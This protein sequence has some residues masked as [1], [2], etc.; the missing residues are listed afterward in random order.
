ME[1]YENRKVLKKRLILLGGFT[2]LFFLLLGFRLYLIQIY[3]NPVYSEQALKQRGREI[4]LN[5]KR[6]IIYD[7]NLIPFTNTKSTKSLILTNDIL[8]YNKEML[9]IVLEYSSLGRYEI[10]D[11]LSSDDE[12]IQ[13]PL[14][15]NI[16]I[17]N[18]PINV[19]LV[20]ITERYSDENILSHV[21]GYVNKKDNCGEA[22]I[23]KVF[24]EFLQSGEKR[25]LFIEYDKDR[26]MILGGSEFVNENTDPMIPEGVKLTID[27]SIQ[28]SVEKIMDANN[29]KGA[30]V[31]VEVD[32]GKVLALASR[33]NYDQEKIESYLDTKD[34]T[35]YNKAIQVGY[36]PGSIFKTVV[37][38]TAIEENLLDNEYYCKGYEDIKNIRIKCTDVHESIN[39]KEGF[40]K[41]CNSVFIQL[42]SKLGSK[43]IIEMAE[44]LN[45]GSKIN[46]GLSEEISGNLPKGDDLLGPAIG[47]ISIGQG[48]I[49]VT[50]LQIANLM[51]TIANGGVQ[52]H[53]TL[54]EGITNNEGK[55]IKEYNK[56]EDRRVLSVSSSQLAMEYLN[57][58]VENGTGKDLDLL[59]VGGS[60]GKTGSA[61]AVMNKNNTIH[62]WFAGYFPKDYPKYV[63]TV[64]VEEGHSG[65]KSAAPIFEK[66][67]KEINKIYPLY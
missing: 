15:N 66:I 59:E 3:K 16:K 38:L 31:V 29:I 49:E 58:V 23:E 4:S 64:L 27:Y 60:G 57:S 9:D 34:M 5:P 61:E 37:L 65:S 8:K 52:K 41:S 28:E 20:D 67:A 42:G 48:K 21:I 51:T 47:N 24:D 30:A 26:S 17:E 44:R 45:F 7:R 25:S 39:L 10:F 11:L 33:P 40:E 35:L 14:K 13:I 43:K 18:K 63:I 12:I 53:L 62:G 22:G 56:E 19:F 32:T 46:I 50:P 1:N 36:P 6:G 55:I 2:T 54:I